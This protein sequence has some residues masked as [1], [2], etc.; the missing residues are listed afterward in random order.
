MHIV[1]KF[2]APTFE[3]LNCNIEYQNTSCLGY[4][5]TRAHIHPSYSVVH[6]QESSSSNKKESEELYKIEGKEITS[7]SDYLVKH[8]FLKMLGKDSIQC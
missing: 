3:N 6:K 8:L 1:A 2:R 7:I 4:Y 5:M